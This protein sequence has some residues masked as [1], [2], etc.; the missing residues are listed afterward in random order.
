VVGSRA[1]DNDRM[2]SDTMDTP[3]SLPA[4]K[5]TGAQTLDFV[6]AL[7]ERCL[8]L[9]GR[10]VT[11]E[12][13]GFPECD[14][15]EIR[16]AFKKLWFALDEPARRRAAKC[17]FLLIDIRFQN[18][19]WWRAVADGATFDDAKISGPSIFPAE[20]A[21]E[22]SAET[23]T[24]AWHTARSDSRIASQVLGLATGVVDIV[25]SLGPREIQRIAA[26]LSHQ[27]RPRWESNPEFWEQLLRTAVGG[28][29]TSMSDFHLHGLQLLGGEFLDQI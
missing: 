18:E 27:L 22:L 8:Q 23:L 4:W 17:P 28:D 26:R 12:D 5:W 11:E 7:N 6:Y 15:L 3:G 19:K 24:V 20:P 9:L 21:R 2:A 1:T 14:T 29:A 10:R 13:R 25:A 16:A